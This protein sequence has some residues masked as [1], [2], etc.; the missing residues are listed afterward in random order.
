MHRPSQ[1][2]LM[3]HGVG[4][5]LDPVQAPSLNAILYRSAPE[6]EPNQLPIGHHPVLPR[7]KLCDLQITWAL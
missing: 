7:R 6:A 2:H 4:A 1:V 3:P 5:E